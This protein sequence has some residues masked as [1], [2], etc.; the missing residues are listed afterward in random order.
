[1][2]R[3]AGFGM[4]TISLRRPAVAVI[5]GVSAAPAAT[6]GGFVFAGTVV[7]EVVLADQAI[8]QTVEADH[9]TAMVGSIESDR[10]A[11]VREA[12]KIEAENVRNGRL[13][14]V[15]WTPELRRELV[16]TGKVKGFDGHH[17]NSVHDNPNLARNPNNIKFT[18][19]HL[20]EHGGNWRNPTKGPLIKRR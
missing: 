14:T 11:A 4:F 16:E 17:I 5:G 15:D 1:M 19:N 3:R 8:E 18:N 13:G 10:R 6:I 9:Q 7:G 20:D 2:G 12:W